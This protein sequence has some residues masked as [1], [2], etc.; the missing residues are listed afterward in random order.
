MGDRRAVAAR[1]RRR[2]DAT[3]QLSVLGRFAKD[4]QGDASGR[5]KNDEVT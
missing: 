4:D 1:H 2:I 5:C 3:A